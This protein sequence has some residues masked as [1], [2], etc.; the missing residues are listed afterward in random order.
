MLRESSAIGNRQQVD[1]EARLFLRWRQ[2]A[3][4]FSVEALGDDV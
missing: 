3:I 4:K 1:V 2:K